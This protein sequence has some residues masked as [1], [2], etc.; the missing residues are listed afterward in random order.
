M[1]PRAS[2]VELGAAQRRL[3]APS[4]ALPLDELVRLATLAASSHNTQ[5]WRFVCG[6][7]RI[8]LRPDFDRRCPVVD[9]DDSHLWKSLGCAVENMVTA[10][11]AFGRGA[12]VAVEVPAGL[13]TVRLPRRGEAR[14]DPL[15]RAI[16]T[17]QCTRGPFDGRPLATAHRAA[18]AA[19]AV[20]EGIRTIWIDDEA[21]RSRLRALVHEG[22]LA[23]LGSRP[24]RRELRSWLRFSTR[25]AIATGDGLAGI[26]SGRPSL[27]QPLGRLLAPLLVTATAQARTDDLQL[28]S[29]PL[30]A[31]IVVDRDEPGRWFEAGRVFER[32]ALQA[33]LLDVR[34]AFVNQPVE[35]RP[36]R[37]RL[38]E[39]V[40]AGSGQPTLLV[41]LGYGAPLP[42]SLRRPLADV[43]GSS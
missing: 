18:L 36:L 20:G 41:R 10:A 2:F 24:F 31:A 3:P 40:G 6:V 23:Q 8:E 17:R 37:A 4:A 7:D 25:A 12:E 11:P 19:V 1:S 9:P 34:V 43:L 27:P 39:A 15:Y 21:R 26:C 32:I 5:P 29:S 13:V 14:A 33:A 30:L 42:P 38:A 16:A 22:N 28:D 35:V